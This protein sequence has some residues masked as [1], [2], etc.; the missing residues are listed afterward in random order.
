VQTIDKVAA[1]PR[2]GANWQLAPQHSL[3]LGA[4]IQHQAP[5]LQLALATRE[6]GSRLNP[7]LDFMRSNQVVLGYTY[8]PNPNWRLG[9]EAYYQHLENVPVTVAPSSYSGL[10]EG[11]NFN[12]LNTDEPLQSTGTGRN[13]GLDLTIERFL[14]NNWYMLVTGSVFDATNVA[15]DGKRYAGAF[16]TQYVASALAGIEFQVGK[17]KATDLFADFTLTMA[18]GRPYTPFDTE[19]SLAVNFPIEDETRAWSLRTG[20]Y[21][22]LDIRTGA[23]FNYKKWSQEMAFYVQNVTNN[24]NEFIRQFDPRTGQEGILYQL[25]FFPVVQY[26]VYF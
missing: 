6:D 19:A 23:R 22:K 8:R 2:I 3:N 16:G 18:G 10:N 1:D 14:S 13:Y 20:S 17:K 9:A 24:Q 25:G 12:R 4:A 21:F 5:L 7:D 26:K 11:A 15:S